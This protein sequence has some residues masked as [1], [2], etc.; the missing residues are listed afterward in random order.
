MAKLFNRIKVKTR[1]WVQI[2]FTALTNGYFIG[3]INGSIYTG[4]AKAVCLPGL[5]CYSCPGAL[6][7]CPIGS[8]QAVFN[9]GGKFSFY[10][11]G[12]FIFVGAV[13]GRLICGWACPFGLFQ[14]ILYKIPFW[15]KQKNLPGHNVLKWLKYVI[16][17]VF[18][19]LLPLFWVDALGLSDPWFCKYICPS[20]TLMSGLPLLIVNENL[21]AAAGGLFIFKSFL[22]M[23]TIGLAIIVYRPF[24]KYICPLGAIYGLFNPIAFY[25][26]QLIGEKCTHCQTC[27]K[28]CPNDIP[29]YDNPNQ[30]ECIRCGKCKNNCPQNAIVV[31]NSKKSEKR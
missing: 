19:I 31:C 12:F 9:S 20:G 23:G 4:K 18:V 13:F 22:L 8:L 21:R 14:D 6:G 29:V 17:I 5:N 27:Q 11:I 10:I 28:V 7:A 26:Y 24:C 16:L 25:R 15:Q 30:I 2:I 3:F 1:L